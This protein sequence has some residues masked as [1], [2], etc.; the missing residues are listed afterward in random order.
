MSTALSVISTLI[1]KNNNYAGH[2]DM[3]QLSITPCDA[4]REPNNAWFNNA[5]NH[6]I[7]QHMHYL[8]G[9]LGVLFFEM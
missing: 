1:D 4:R 3:L 7:E 6:W 5:H 9:L 8:A 2:V